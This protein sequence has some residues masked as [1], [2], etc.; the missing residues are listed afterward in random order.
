MPALQK[1]CMDT[2]LTVYFAVAAALATAESWALCIIK[3]LLFDVALA[4]VL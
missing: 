1:N 2:L 4:F 3:L